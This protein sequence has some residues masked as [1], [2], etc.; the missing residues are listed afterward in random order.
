MIPRILVADRAKKNNK[1]IEKEK[2]TISSLINTEE[3]AVFYSFIKYMY[4]CNLSIN[5]SC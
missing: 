1:K 5:C 2:E 3:F 4:M